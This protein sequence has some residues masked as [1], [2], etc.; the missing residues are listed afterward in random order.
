MPTL[1]ADPV[2][3][4][5]SVKWMF[6]VPARQFQGD[7]RIFRDAPA[8]IVGMYLKSKHENMA[9]IA[10]QANAERNLRENRAVAHVENELKKIPQRT[11]TLAEEL[12][13]ATRVRKEVLDILEGRK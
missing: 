2:S 7:Q 1:S 8:R 6:R 5:A 3:F 9:E 13:I 4:W 12:E 10:R 11:I